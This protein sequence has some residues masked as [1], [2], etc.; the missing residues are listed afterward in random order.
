[1]TRYG[2]TTRLAC[3]IAVV[4]AT[5]A[6]AAHAF[7]PAAESQNFQKTAERER[8]V[9]KTPEFQAR[10]AQQEVQD[11][12]DLAQIAAAEAPALAAG[13]GRNFAGNICFQRKR[14]CAGDVRFYDWEASVPGA[15]VEP[16]LF[17]ARSGATISGNVWAVEP[18]AGPR[19]A[20]VITTG[21]IQAPET[22]YWGFA[23]YLAQR[24]YVVLTYDVQGQGRSDTFGED[25][26]RDE[27]VPAQ[28]P[29]NFVDGTEDAL[30]FMLSRP[31]SPYT[32]RP[33]CT[34]GT[35]HAPRHAARVALGL[36]A[37]FNPLHGVVDADRIGLA[38]QSLGASAVSFAG[39]KD[40][41][42][43]AIVAW[44]NL[45]GPGKKSDCASAPATREDAAITKPA[46][47]IS[48]DYGIVAQ[49]FT[50]DPDPEGKTGAF[51]QYAAA[52]VDSM[53]VNIRGG[54]HFEAAFIPG[55][56]AP[57]L[58][59]AT[60]RGYDLAAWYTGAWFDRYVKC[61]GDAACAAAAERQLLTDRWRADARNGEVDAAGDPNLFSFYFRSR[62]SLT[63]AAGRVTCDDMRAGCASMGPDGG[64][65]DFSLLGS[66]FSRAG[67]PA[68][69]GTGGGQGGG[70]GSTAEA[71]AL[72]QGGGP[73]T[74]TLRGTDAGDALRGAEGDDRLA[75]RGGDDCLFGQAGNDRLRG[76]AG[77][78]S[79]KG[80]KG[81]DRLRAAD[82]ERD[83][84][85]C[86]G[87][88]DDRATVDRR[89][90]RVSG[91][92]TV[93]RR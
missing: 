76:D 70:S 64:P 91:C 23:A 22:L 48:N 5:G 73:G 31:A 43:D 19:P 84:V 62:Y 29:A 21:S 87:G 7:D 88:K 67:A 17:T 54:T 83:R 39:Q 71:C 10:L 51:E 52:G 1:V 8:Y 9:V 57:A 25:P 82:G 65:A 77:R 72:G 40:P 14:E 34:S 32:P 50:S 41:R 60:L 16:V 33:S 2:R 53:Q 79:L 28:Q 61:Q 92:E 80:G 36:N 49:P 63:T 86:G 30:D 75:G 59:L 58:G 27:G 4:C 46:L 47:G 55:Q 68:G 37:P 90:D 74:D 20:V 3:L 85:S 78:D 15:V 13:H 18:G 38:G 81:N 66:A 69:G 56:T 93:R 11:N 45:A 6:P 89:I 42:V 26:D 12:A 44:D 35:S 24:G